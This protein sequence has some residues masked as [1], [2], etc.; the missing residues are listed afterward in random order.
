MNLQPDELH[1][2]LEPPLAVL[3]YQLWGV[4]VILQHFPLLRV[5]VEGTSGAINIGQVGQ[6]SHQVIDSLRL[7]GVNT[8]H[9]QLEISSPGLNRRLFTLAQCEAFIGQ[10]IVVKLRQTL[11]GRQRYKGI[12]TA[13][14][15]ENL[16]IQP[17]DLD[18]VE[19]PWHNVAKANVV[20]DLH[21]Y[22]TSEKK[23]RRS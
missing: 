19:C 3:G 15:D 18:P 1:A 23:V 21:A 14:K 20:A 22:L 16:L 7:A 4:E 10:E 17:Q 5:Y 9:L 12:L 11:L 8:E 13:I 6:A 2:L